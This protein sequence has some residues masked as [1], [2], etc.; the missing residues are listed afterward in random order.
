MGYSPWGRKESGTTER[1]YLLTYKLIT[2]ILMSVFLLSKYILLF[3][4]YILSTFQKVFRTPWK[5]AFH[6][7]LS[8]IFSRQECWSGLPYISPGDL[9]HSR[10]EPTLDLLLGPVSSL[11]LAPPGKPF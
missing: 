4:K 11:P 7:P 8:M 5:V 3:S 10:M 2:E 1:P 6:V 9:L